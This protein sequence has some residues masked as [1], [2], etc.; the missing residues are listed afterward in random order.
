M[1]C[2]RRRTT[3]IVNQLL[4]SAVS[5]FA[6]AITATL[7][8]A[9][10]SDKLTYNNHHESRTSLRFRQ[11]SSSEVLPVLTDR[12]HN[13]FLATSILNSL[14]SLSPKMKTKT[15]IEAVLRKDVAVSSTWNQCTNF[16]PSATVYTW[17]GTVNGKT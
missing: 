2:C 9:T 14:F 7:K 11:V 10:G 16:E 1:C 17:T 6:A 4:L 13:S 15:Q 12:K 3:I 5:Q 8:L